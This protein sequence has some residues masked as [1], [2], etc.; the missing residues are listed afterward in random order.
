M[1]LLAA[2]V[3]LLA[4]F[5][6]QAPTTS[7]NAP[8]QPPLATLTAHREKTVYKGG[9]FLNRARKRVG[10]ATLK[11]RRLSRANIKL[12]AFICPTM[13]KFTSLSDYP[14]REGC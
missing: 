12:S 4:N 3:L 2:L 8:K 11:A 1:R 6:L 7:D 10:R 9:L 14:R 5:V 13:T